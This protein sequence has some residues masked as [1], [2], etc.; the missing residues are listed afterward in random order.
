MSDEET[1]KPYPSTG[2][3][4]DGMTLPK[5]AGVAVPR[6][7]WRTWC[8]RE[9]LLGLIAPELLSPHWSISALPASLFHCFTILNQFFFRSNPD[10]PTTVSSQCFSPCP[11]FSFVRSWSVLLCSPQV[12]SGL[13][14]SSFQLLLTGCTFAPS[15]PSRCSL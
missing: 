8:L 15:D 4:R 13:N 10:F 14:Q 3:L 9:A 12:F 11:A 7:S 5:Q 2:K 6:P 1:I